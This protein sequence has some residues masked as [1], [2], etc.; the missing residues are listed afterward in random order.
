MLVKIN[1][2]PQMSFEQFEKTFRQAFGRD[3]TSEERMW[4]RFPSFFNDSAEQRDSK[5]DDA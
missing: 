2:Q 4:L 5:D 1:G 3:M